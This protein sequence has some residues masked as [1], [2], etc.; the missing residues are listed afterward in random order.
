MND[1]EI[2]KLIKD[3]TPELEAMREK[4]EAVFDKA[5][6]PELRENANEVFFRIESLLEYVKFFF[7]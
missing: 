5:E 2:K 1:A 3:L 7:N 4:L 6:A